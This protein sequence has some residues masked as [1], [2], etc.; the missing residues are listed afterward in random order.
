MET[1]AGLF[2]KIFDHRVRQGDIRRILDTLSREERETF[3][4]KL[5]E[6]LRKITAH[7]EVSNR[8]SD[9]LSLDELLPRLIELTTDTLT[10][11]RGTIFLIDRASD[12]LFSRGAMGDLLQEIRLPSSKGIAGAV[13]TNGKPVIIHDAY[14]DPRFNPEV[15][16]KTGYK[17]R[18]ILCAPI[19]NKNSEIV[20]V[21]QLINKKEGDFT[22]SDLSL[23]EAMSTQAAAALKNAQLFE[24]VERARRE[25]AKLNELTKA[26]SSELQLTPL[27]NKIMET[28]TSI[29]EAD[30]S[31]LFL[32][33]DKSSELWSRVAQDLGDVEIRI[34]DHMGIAGS[35]FKSG[36]AVLIHDPYAD[37]R[38]NPEIDR[39]TGYSTKNI[40]AAPVINKEGKTI[41][42]TQVLNKKAGSFTKGDESRLMAFSVQASIAIENAKLFEDVLNMKNYNES[43]L[44]SLSNGVITMNEDNVI[45]KC[46][47]AAMKILDIKAEAAVGR[48]VDRVFLHENH[49]VSDSVKKVKESGKPD[50]T[51]DNELTIEGGDVISVNL[52]VVPLINIKD[53]FMGTMLV[54]EDISSEKRIKGTLARYMTKEV[55]DQ[56]IDSAETILGGQIKQASILFSDIRNFT[57]L[58]EQ[59]GPQETVTMLNEYFTKMVDILFHYEG[60]LDKYIGDAILA[61]FGTPFGS[62]RA[63]DQALKSAIDMMRALRLFNDK[64]RSEKKPG[65]DIGIGISTDEVLVGNIGSMKR[66]DYTVIGDGVNLASRLESANKYYGTNILLSKF[67]L[68]QLTEKYMLRQVDLIKVKGKSRPVAI[69]EALDFHDEKDFPN[70]AEVMGIFEEGITTYRKMDWKGAIKK[71]EKLLALYPGDRLSRM[72][73]ERCQHFERKPPPKSWDGVW[74][75]TMK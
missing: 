6:L 25:Q 44:E 23:L 50:I 34:P 66:M 21:I 20:G 24:Q 7:M 9:S 10:A 12:E 59:I 30:R 47:T 71:F 62:G 51:L 55:A 43:I 36:E 58:S 3:I 18:N 26:I 46:N 72:Y 74:I 1:K 75:M 15:D 54:F 19:R 67:T 13:Y 29:L 16:K 73:V 11:D 2:N 63:A 17:T 69:Y 40:L 61:V 37:P 31:T 48:H 28:T 14:S 56:L 42:V 70:A 8:M 27:L 64:R 53:I 33:D 5:S 39:K 68:D 35:V 4:E 45:E 57:T 60:I 22:E 41:G 65:I 49:W 38:F 32:H 52:T